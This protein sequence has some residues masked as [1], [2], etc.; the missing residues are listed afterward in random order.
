MSL[1]AAQIESLPRV[2]AVLNYL[3]AMTEKPRNYTYEPPPGIPQNNAVYEPHRLA[4]S[5]AR[6]FADRLS[7]DEEGLALV[8]HQS[9]VGDFYD[10]DALRQVYYPEA[11]RLVA[12]ATGAARVLVFDHTIRRRLP[13]TADRTA[14]APRQPV[15]RV[16]NDYTV[17]SGP[18]RV[19]D[20]LGEEADALLRRRFSVINVWRP[21]R[22]PLRDAPLAVCDARSV[23]FQDLVASDLVY[24]DRTGETYAVR[25]NPAHRWFYVPEMRVDEA[26]LLKCYDSATDGR[27]RFAPHT[28]FEDPT[29]PADVLPRESI[30]LRTLAFYIA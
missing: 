18:Q 23:A 7:L 17:K 20:L 21:I 9:A 12:A 8:D 11:E 10:E 6:P 27:A 22:G 15:P 2:E 14:G 25:F 13:D 26:L 19:R 30:E 16:H 1:S 28:A 3:A 5:N 29:A 4:I 24:P